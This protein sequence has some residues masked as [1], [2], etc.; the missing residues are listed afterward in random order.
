MAYD[1]DTPTGSD[2]HNF[3][4]LFGSDDEASDIDDGRSQS[5][6]ASRRE[7]K[8]LT[9]QSNVRDQEEEISGTDDLFG[10]DEEDTPIIKPQS[11]RRTKSYTHYESEEERSAS[12][13]YQRQYDNEDDDE[14]SHRKRIEISLEMPALPLPQS[15]DG[16]FYWTKLPKFLD[17]DRNRF[18]P[19]SFEIQTE[20]G[21]TDAQCH[22]VVRQQVEST[23]RWRKVMNDKN[24][25]EIQ[26]NSHL[27]E[28]E[29]GTMSLMVGNECFDATQKVA[30]PQE[31][32]YML[33]QHKQLGALESH[34][35]ITDHMTFRPSDLKSETHRHLTAQIAN[36]H[37][38][39]IKTKMFFTEKD[40]EKLKQEL[41]LKE[42]ERLRAQKKLEN[43]RKKTDVR[44]GSH[45]NTR[46][47][48]HEEISYGSRSRVNH[49]D[50]YEEDFVNDEEYDED[51]EK[52]R[53]QRLSQAKRGSTNKYKRGYSD[54]EEEE[55]EEEEEDLGYEED[56][57]EDGEEEEE[58]E[59]ETVTIRR[60]KRRRFSSD[61]D[62]E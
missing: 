21:L 12:P 60:P 33:A 40:P 41:E 9:P 38:K 5:S 44:Y 51:E 42:S 39:K 26:S 48:G 34:T 37:V 45:S 6:H 57:V 17:I 49:Q 29:D 19:E 18:K 36:K 55:E 27:V 61:E 52:S 22:E 1:N 59:D 14:D 10:S 24:D 43:Q 58:E 8:A 25:H 56:Q 28:W 2:D 4:G 30:A 50:A 54:E 31:H 16:K 11:P 20:E 35:E 53:E 13:K 32:V 62:E 3:D 47:Y 7:P 15:D 23:I 46:E